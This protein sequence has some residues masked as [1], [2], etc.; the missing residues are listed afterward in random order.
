MTLGL[1]VILLTGCSNNV[2]YLMRQNSELTGKITSMQQQISDMQAEISVLKDRKFVQLP[3][4]SPTV[5]EARKNSNSQPVNEEEAAFNQALQAYKSGDVGE[6]IGQF[7]GFN[8]RFP[9][10]TKR[11]DVLYYTAEAYYTQRQYG[12]S[13]ELLEA[14]IYQ[15]PQNQ[16]NVNAVPQLKRIYEAQNNS[17]KMAELD[18]F[19]SRMNTES[20]Y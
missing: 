1:P 6:A 5:A 11:A 19:I 8:S 18:S 13:Q 12:R 3:T 14:L 2:D 15:Y 20:T 9:N 17:E 16:V 7:E 10:S 4:G